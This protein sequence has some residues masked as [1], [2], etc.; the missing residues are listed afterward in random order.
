MIATQC[1]QELGR[2]WRYRRSGGKF[3][4]TLVN[5]LFYGSVDFDSG[6]VNQEDPGINDNA[7]QQYSYM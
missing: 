5:L 2:T 3:C 6:L 4:L 7:V 1:F